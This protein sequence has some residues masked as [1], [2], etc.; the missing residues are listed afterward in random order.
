MSSDRTYCIFWRA[1]PFVSDSALHE[2]SIRPIPFR[3][4]R[5]G[6]W[7]CLEAQRGIARTTASLVAGQFLF[8]WRQMTIERRRIS[9]PEQEPLFVHG[10]AG[11][12]ATLPQPESVS[13]RGAGS[14]YLGEVSTP[15]EKNEPFFALHS[16]ASFSHLAVRKVPA[17]RGKMIS[18]KK[19]S[20]MV[21]TKK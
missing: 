8:C 7:G 1:L 12:T 11:A 21:P 6:T 18:Q 10:H 9:A 17:G 5:G 14:A 19:C 13:E 2:S 16:F 20:I 3:P 4:E 15:G